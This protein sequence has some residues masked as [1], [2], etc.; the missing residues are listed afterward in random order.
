MSPRIALLG[1]MLESNAFSPV[2]DETE[3]REK[4]WIEGD[5][6]VDDARSTAPRDPGGFTGFCQAMDKSGSWT[7]VPIA[8]TTAGASGPVDQAFFDRYVAM[9]EQRLAAAL[10]LDGVYIQAHGAARGT[11][12]PDPEGF[13]FRAVRA[14]VGPTVPIVATLDL[15]ANVSREMVAQTDL[16][17]AYRTNPHTDMRERGYEAGQA[18]REL[19]GGLRVAKAFVKL[20]ILPPQ[21]AL[22]SDRGPYGEAIAKGQARLTDA[23]LNVSVLGNFSFAD[24]P[25][26]GMSVIVTARGGQAAASDLARELAQDLWD[27][28]ER[29]TPNLVSIAQATQRM[30]EV[31]EDPRK[32]PLLFAD[33]ADNPGGGGRGNTTAMLKSFLD[34]GVR[35]AAFAVHYDPPLVAEAHRLGRAARFTALLNRNETD[36]RSERLEAEA[37][38]MQLSDG[39]IVGRRGTIGGRKFSLGASAWLRLVDRIDLVIISIRHQCFDTEML[40]HLGLEVRRL[41]GIVVKSRG[42]FRAGF[43][44]IFPDERILEVDGPGLATPILTRVAWKSVPRP[45]WPLDPEMPWRVPVNVIVR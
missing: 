18:M 44:D 30:L 21:V 33:V 35:G 5:A 4:H 15:H 29:L 24:S 2:A 10:P 17:V 34:A 11:I 32:P 40:E 19:L 39:E 20:P 16:L 13:F 37:E 12:E 43:D 1:F 6:I 3:F 9:I 36:A 42:H 7:P 38:V 45:I 22:L 26:T 27:Q 8:M 25:K 28:R 41:R 31:G 14:I 23:I